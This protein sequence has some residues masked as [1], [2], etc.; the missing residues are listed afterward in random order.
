MGKAARRKKVDKSPLA[1]GEGRC[2]VDPSSRKVAAPVTPSP[3]PRAWRRWV[4]PA[5]CALLVVSFL[6]LKC[7]ALHPQRVDEGIYFYDA[8]RLA[9]GVRLYRDLFFAHPPLQLV[10]P[11]LLVKLLG[12][13]FLPLKWLPQLFGAA[14]GVLAYLLARRVLARNPGE[15]AELAG[16]LACATLLFAEDFLKASSYFT[17][18]NQA[19]ALLFAGLFAVL[20]RGPALGGVLAGAGAMVLLQVAPVAAVL[21]VWLFLTDKP[22]ARRYAIGLGAVLLLVHLVALVR[23]GG[24][25]V[26]Q[27]YLYQLNKV[28]TEGSGTAQIGFLLADDTLLLAGGTVALGLGCFLESDARARSVLRLLAACVVVETFAMATRPKVF[29]FYFQPAFLPC[30]LGLGWAASAGVRRFLEGKRVAGAALAAGPIAIPLVLGAQLTSVFSPARA[31]QRRT[32]AQ[33]YHWQDAPHLGPLNGV[34]RALFWDDGIR[35]ADS[36][37]LAVTEYLWNQSRGFDACP[38]IV[39]QVTRTSGPDDTLFG[40]SAAAPLVAFL[41]GRRLTA[42]LAD[43]NVQRFTS[44]ATT[45]E[46]GV[47]L[48]EREGPPRLVIASGH[49]GLFSLPGW[50]TWLA[51]HY[52]R[53]RDFADSN[54]TQYTLYQRQ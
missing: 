51:A 46:E 43:T 1:D 45:V 48:V 2:T 6:A 28:A 18:I 7:F 50:Q 16:V 37:H 35:T 22:A 39:E 25:F 3:P 11:T 34:V 52:V 8:Q 33:V 30:A 20:V 31:E 40:D 9:D 24:A 54:G 15:P 14:Q 32:Y 42:D 47:A 23:G 17:D 27:V 49:A 19:D 4:G 5:L 26:N 41:A 13:A 38:A 12:N 53:A 36:S 29:P 21:G 44:G 10:L